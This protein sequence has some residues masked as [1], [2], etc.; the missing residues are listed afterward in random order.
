M[1]Q[2]TR[3]LFAPDVAFDD[4][5]F[6]NPVRMISAFE[7]RIVGF[8]LSPGLDLARSGAAFGSGVLASVT[9]DAVA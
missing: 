9:I 1:K 5:D 3:L 6:G 4:L 8:Y 7:A 2:G